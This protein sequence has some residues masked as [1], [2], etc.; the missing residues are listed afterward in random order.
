LFFLQKP[1]V[2]FFWAIGFSLLLSF[3][4]SFT[5][6]YITAQALPREVFRL[7]IVAASDSAEDQAVKFLIR[8][9]ILSSGLLQKAKNK[10]EAMQIAQHALPEFEEMA[11]GILLSFGKNAVAKV[12]V[13]ECFFPTRHYETVTLPA[14][15][16]DALNITVGEGTGKNWWCVLY[17]SLCIPCAVPE[18]ELLQMEKESAALIQDYEHCRFQFAAVEWIESIKNRMKS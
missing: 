6:F 7:H 18:E 10:E 8:D 4:L 14:G 1:W 5:S 15:C 3:V 12:S 9:R 16:Y 13:E 11:N 2:R 17:P